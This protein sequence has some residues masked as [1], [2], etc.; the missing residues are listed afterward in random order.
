MSGEFYT[1]E[2]GKLAGMNGRPV[3][4]TDAVF[5]DVCCRVYWCYRWKEVCSWNDGGEEPYDPPFAPCECDPWIPRDWNYV[6]FEGETPP[7]GCF[8]ISR[9]PD[10]EGS[11]V[12]IDRIYEVLCGP[13]HGVCERDAAIAD[14]S[15][16]CEE[17]E[18]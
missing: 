14:G 8:R 11:W 13:F 15:C 6:W 9:P 7:E 18:I 1:L 12:W 2:D 10:Y 17:E 16:V 5:E 4:Y 3:K